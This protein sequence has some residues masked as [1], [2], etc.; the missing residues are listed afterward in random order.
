[1]EVNSQDIINTLK[2]KIALYEHLGIQS[3]NIEPHRVSFK[4][5][6]AKNTNHK[7]TAFGGSIYAVAVLA[8]YAMVLTGLKARGIPTEDIVIAKGDIQYIEPVE[9]DFEVVCEFPDT[10]SEHDF[11]EEL[12]AA[13]KVRGALH[14]YILAE[15]GSRKAS[16]KGVFVVK[17]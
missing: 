8:S 5:S 10:R 6:L 3:V 9:T 1:M 2:K 16:L 11:Y 15:G 14:S 12:R 7:G 13:G 4:V 17:C